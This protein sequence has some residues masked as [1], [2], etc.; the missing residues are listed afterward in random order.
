MA[1]L[2]QRLAQSRPI[3]LDGATGTELERRGVPMNSVAWSGV[4]VATHPDVVRQVHLDY[5]QAGAEII[6]T[7]TFASGRQML[8]AAGCESRTQEINRQAAQLALQAREQATAAKA[9]STEEVWSHAPQTV[10]IAG[11][12]SAM[13]AG[14][15]GSALPPLHEMRSNFAEQAELLADAGVDLLILEMMRDIDYSCA[16]L[17]AAAATGLPVWVGFSCERTE[18]GNLKLAPPIADEIA[19]DAGVAAVMAEGGELAAVMHSDVDVTG[20]ALAAIQAVWDGPTGAYPES[21]YFTMPNWQFVDI[22][23]PDEFAYEAMGWV[24][25]GAQ[26]VG[27]C[28]GIG[29]THIQALAERLRCSDN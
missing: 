20:A 26:L 3:L 18:E 15:G 24:G 7:N 10:W 14:E 17:E 27:G 22:I 9:S 8:R 16:A 13:A 4:A 12:I 1:T 5:I 11:S 19:L 2:S 6:I 25:Q 28:C 29:T 23:P 21:G